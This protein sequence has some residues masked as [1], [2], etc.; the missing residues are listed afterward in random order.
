VGT[1]EAITLKENLQTSIK[2]F[3]SVDYRFFDLK[4]LMKDGDGYYSV[5]FKGKDNLDYRIDLD[6]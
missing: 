6:F 1:S 5:S 4:P 2:C 3:H